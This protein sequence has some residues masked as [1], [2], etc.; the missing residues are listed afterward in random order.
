LQGVAT[1]SLSSLSEGCSGSEQFSKSTVSQF[2]PVAQRG[3]VSTIEISCEPK[4]TE[5]LETP[6]TPLTSLPTSTVGLGVPNLYD[7]FTDGAPVPSSIPLSTSS[8]V[9]A[10]ANHEAPAP[11]NVIGA[12]V[13]PDVSSS[14]K[15]FDDLATNV[16]DDSP[17]SCRIRSRLAPT[18]SRDKAAECEA[19]QI[20]T[21]EFSDSITAAVKSKR[22][23]RVK[24]PPSFPQVQMYCL[25]GPG[26]AYTDFHIDF[27]GTSVWYH[28]VHGEKWFYF[29]PPT[30][31]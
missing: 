11:T 12:V 26:N 6:S 9:G 23:K 25:M 27:G 19:L 13:S 18:L 31:G 21:E 4:S 2:S 10:V 15:A 24:P 7:T 17:I 30:P 20:T 14:P 5:N 22:R 3:S 16:N 8:E 28:L 1:N 29:I